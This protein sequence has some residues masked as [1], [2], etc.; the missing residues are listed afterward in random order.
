MNKRIKLLSIFIVLFIIGSVCVFSVYAADES[1]N[2]NPETPPVVD[3]NP[4]VVDPVTP[5]EG[6]G[7]TPVEPSSGESGGEVVDPTTDTG[8]GEVVDPTTETTPVNPTP[9]DGNDY[10]YDEDDMVNN[11]DDYAGNVSDYTNLYDTSDFDENAYKK[12]KWDDITIDVSKPITDTDAM[13]F[14]AIKDDTSKK[15]DGQL[16]LYIGY[17]LIALSIV[18][19]IYFIVS[20]ATYKKKLKALKAREQR[21]RTRSSERSRSDYGDLSE[22]PTQRDYNQRYRRYSND[23]RS[24]A[25]RKRD[26]K[27]DTAEIK[28]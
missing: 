6:G 13:D 3:P 28:F 1:V 5:S 22:F 27:A 2:P 10:Y 16:I 7:E 15:D 26:T 17:V 8:T 21:Q 9:P 12:T 11:I 24:Y 14:S 4:P 19:I 20:T 18:G 23:N 25:Q